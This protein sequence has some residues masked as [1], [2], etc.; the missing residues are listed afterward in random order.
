MNLQKYEIIYD[1]MTKGPDPE[2]PFKIIPYMAIHESLL[3]DSL[4]EEGL[5][6]E[7]M[8]FR[9]HPAYIILDAAGFIGFFSFRIAG[10]FPFL[11]HFL[12]LKDRR[13]LQNA[14]TLLGGFIFILMTMGFVMFI[15]EVPAG[16][17]YLRRF[18][19]YWA[20]NRE[21]FSRSASGDEYYLMPILRHWG[22]AA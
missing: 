22:E 19:N 15:A 3:K 5:Q 7:E 18:V 14:V 10:A 17:A 8:T 16:K 11:N 13:T 1:A 12:V 20:G 9:D 4:R 2:K 21:P 6:D